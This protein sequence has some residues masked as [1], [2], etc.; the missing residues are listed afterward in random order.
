MELNVFEGVYHPIEWLYDLYHPSDGIV[1]F[2]IGACEG[3]SA[4]FYNIRF[5]NAQLYAFEPVP[6]NFEW[7]QK[8]TLSYPSIQCFQVAL[9]NENGE[10][11]FHL[12]SGTPPDAKADQQVNYGNKSSS[13]FAP[14]LHTSTHPWLTFEKKITVPTRRLAD[15]C[16]ERNISK[17][18]FIHIDVQGAE[19]MVLEGADSLIKSIDCIWME[20]EE[21]ELY[22]DQPLKIDVEKF[23]NRHHFFKVLDTTDGLSGDQFYVNKPFYISKKGLFYWY[24]MRTKM[25]FLDILKII[26]RSNLYKQCMYFKNKIF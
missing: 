23:M 5:P 24:I 6:S 13:L 8:N 19:L 7:I 22:Q 14:K 21:I 2:D 16:Q 20:V 17:I 25:K 4:I 9:S 18:N 3:K 26:K 10:A 12:S 15:F 1:V 11:T